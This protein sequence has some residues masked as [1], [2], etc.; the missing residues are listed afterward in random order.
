MKPQDQSKI[1]LYRA[2]PRFVVSGNH[3]R[4]IDNRIK[5]NPFHLDAY[6]V[7]EAKEQYCQFLR[8][9]SVA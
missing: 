2:E 7:T 3:C 8:Y 5:I 4:L 9:G 1:A 6:S